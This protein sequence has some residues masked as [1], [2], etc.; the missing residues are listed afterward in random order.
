MALM[1]PFSFLHPVKPG[2]ELQHNGYE[3][4]DDKNS[5]VDSFPLVFT[6]QI[7]AFKD[8]DDGQDD[9]RITEGVMHH[10]PERSCLGLW[11][12]PQKYGKQYLYRLDG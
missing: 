1:F 2:D 7:N 12:G 3:A 6:Q 11:L 4:Q 8:V 5:D 9:D 10:I